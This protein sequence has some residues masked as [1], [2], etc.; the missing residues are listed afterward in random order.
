MV[1]APG[2][3]VFVI[4]ADPFIPQP[5]SPIRRLHNRLGKSVPMPLDL[6]EQPTHRQ[7]PHPAGELVGRLVVWDVWHC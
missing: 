2:S 4:F 3:P 1:I 6:R 7:F 5:Y